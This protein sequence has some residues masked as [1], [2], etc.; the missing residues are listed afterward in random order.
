LNL[1]FYA[2]RKVI[3]EAIPESVL[4]QKRPVLALI[5]SKDTPAAN[6]SSVIWKGNIYTRR[7]S[8]S[9]LLLFIDSHLKAKRGDTS[10]FTE[11][12][13]IYKP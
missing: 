1:P 7:T 11:Y 12:S 6:K 8:E 13:L 5:E 4:Q 2:E 9:R 3:G 10:G